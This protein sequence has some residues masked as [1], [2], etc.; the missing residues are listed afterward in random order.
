MSWPYAISPHQTPYKSYT[1]STRG[2]I[3]RTSTGTSHKGNPISRT[4]GKT[5]AVFAVISLL[6]CLTLTTPHKAQAV[7]TLSQGYTTSDPVA[8]GSFVSLVQG[9]TDKVKASDTSNIDSLLG[10]VI[11]ANNALLSVNNGTESQIQVATSGVAPIL[12]SDVNGD[13]KKGDYITA[14]PL[15][16]VGMKATTST[17]SMGIAQDDLTAKNSTKTQVDEK[18][19]GKKEVKLGQI[20]LLISVAYYYKQPDKTLIPIAVQNVANAFAGKKVN[21][22][23]ILVS[24]GIFVITIILVSAI[25][26]TMVRSSII[27]V[28][29]NPLSQSAIYRQVINMSALVIG[30]LGVAVV[31]IYLILKKF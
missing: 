24:L 3:L 17:K 13:I 27:S 16:G 12:V 5:L 8:I 25:V 6:T 21:A 9:T 14:S 30:I 10:I 20:P 15:K 18:G 19:V 26:Y 7:T 22:T 28:G 31:S 29:R 1:V 23:P 4:R 11:T 2:N